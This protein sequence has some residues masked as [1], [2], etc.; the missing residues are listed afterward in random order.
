MQ[1]F[2]IS[3]QSRVFWGPTSIE[4]A[5]PLPIEKVRPW[6]AQFYP[7][8]VRPR[9]AQMC[10]FGIP[11]KE[12]NPNGTYCLRNGFRVLIAKFE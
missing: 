11:F 7:Q 1:R 8:N 12:R 2:F 10:L 9:S 6:S 4:K 3:R 5:Q